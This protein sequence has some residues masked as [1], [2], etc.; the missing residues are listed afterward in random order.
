MADNKRT[1]TEDDIAKLKE[2]AGRI[3]REEIAAQ[4]GR[5]P[6]ATAMVASKLGVS[7]RKLPGT[8]RKG[9]LTH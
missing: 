7:L 8:R 3:P 1:W 2:M 9:Q 5:T 4:L 6:A